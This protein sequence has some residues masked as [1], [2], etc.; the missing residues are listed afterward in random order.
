MPPNGIIIAPPLPA[1]LKIS[2][3]SDSI[4]GSLTINEAGDSISVTTLPFRAT[5]VLV[6]C[7]PLV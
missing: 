2:A 5:A 3:G 4:G 7:Q 1:G 6:P